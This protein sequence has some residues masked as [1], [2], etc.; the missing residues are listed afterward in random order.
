MYFL[1]QLFYEN[2][3]ILKKIYYICPMNREKVSLGTGN[4]FESLFDKNF[5]SFEK[6]SPGLDF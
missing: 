2:Y 6:W 1:A 5:Y 4:H 3:N